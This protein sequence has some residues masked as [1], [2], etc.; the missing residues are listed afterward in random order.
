VTH[1]I[2]ARVEHM[3]R[4]ISKRRGERCQNPVTGGWFLYG[5]DPIAPQK[6]DACKALQAREWFAKHGPPDAQP[7]PVSQSDIE[8]MKYRHSA[9]DG[10]LS[11]IVSRFA[12]S[13]RC[14]GWDFDRHPSFDDFARGVMATRNASFA[15]DFVLK[16]EAMRRRYP[17]RH[18]AGLTPSWIWQPPAN[19][20]IEA[21]R[22]AFGQLPA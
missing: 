20:V 19:C 3:F 6:E 7:L 17:A 1:S 21:Y 16:D 9:P 11:H 12:A 13:L 18:L 22:R 5:D 8:D 14:Q 4:G 2:Q 10:P 15:L